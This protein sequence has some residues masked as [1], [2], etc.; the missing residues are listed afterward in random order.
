MRSAELQEKNYTNF[1]F[2]TIMPG[3]SYALIQNG[4]CCGCQEMCYVFCTSTLI[5]IIL[6]LSHLIYWCFHM[7][8]PRNVK[9]IGSRARY[10]AESPS[11]PHSFLNLCSLFF[12][13]P[14]PT[15]AHPR[16]STSTCNLELHFLFSLPLSPLS[17]SH[18]HT[19]ACTLRTRFPFELSWQLSP[20]PL[21]SPSSSSSPFFLSLQFK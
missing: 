14:P 19:C 1:V 6:L 21:S 17:V 3:C 20:A 15:H 13:S 18:M 4:V 10:W 9:H 5:I 11:S 12:P 2:P 16:C 8:I 7:M